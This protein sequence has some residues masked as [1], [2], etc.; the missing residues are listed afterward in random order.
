MTGLR[1]SK[2]ILIPVALVLI[3]GLGALIYFMQPPSEQVPT[4]KS[5]PAIISESTQTPESTD[6]ETPTPTQTTEPNITKTPAPTTKQFDLP[7]IT[8]D[9][10]A[11]WIKVKPI[12]FSFDSNVRFDVAI[13]T[14]SGSLDFDLTKISLLKDDKGNEYEALD[15]EGSP[16]EGHHRSGI[17][18][19]PKLKQDTTSIELIITDVY[20]VPE[21][22]FY[23]EL[24][25]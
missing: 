25:K 9:E 19:F 23:W 22:I 5:T 20:D 12:D 16:P 14:H 7:S 10:N 3:I 6:T 24:S 1:F 8:N 21:R 4:Y 17:L 15:W 18:T 13:D 11:V 2:M